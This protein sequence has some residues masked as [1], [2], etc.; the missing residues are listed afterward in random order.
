MPADPQADVRAFI[1]AA[2]VGSPALLA[3]DVLEG[4]EVPSSTQEG[5]GTV[6]NRA[7]FV[8][9]LASSEPRRHHDGTALAGALVQVTIRSNAGDYDGGKLLADQ[10]AAALERAS[11]SADY[12]VEGCEL[13]QARPSYMSTDEVGR[14]RWATV[15]R[16]LY[17]A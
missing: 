6:P 16:C 14:H 8:R 9:E 17:V 13:T 5:A 11:L 10:V 15:V 2:A 1:I 4:V 3:A 7:V 12:L